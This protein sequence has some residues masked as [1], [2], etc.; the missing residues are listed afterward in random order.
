M[1]RMESWCPEETL[2]SG[3]CTTKNLKSSITKPERKRVESK[4]KKKMLIEVVGQ[5]LE[6]QADFAGI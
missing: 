6:L 3:T 5:G 2:R 4:K 1:N